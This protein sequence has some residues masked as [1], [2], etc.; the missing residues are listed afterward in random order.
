MCSP[1]AGRWAGALAALLAVL[2]GS[3][4]A[5]KTY[6]IFTRDDFVKFMKTEKDQFHDL[7]EFLKPTG[8]RN[9]PVRDFHELFEGNA[10]NAQAHEVVIRE[11]GATLVDSRG[12]EVDDF[13]P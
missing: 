8:G 1:S 3:A 12:R 13:F 9:A 7:D 5:Q 4:L 10:F 6:P 2:A 11:E